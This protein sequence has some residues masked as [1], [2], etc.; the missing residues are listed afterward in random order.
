MSTRPGFGW[1][2]IDGPTV[3]REDIQ[4]R[5]IRTKTGVARPETSSGSCGILSQTGT[6]V[7]S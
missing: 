7:P 6:A 1:S 4:E 3:A 5:L 2:G